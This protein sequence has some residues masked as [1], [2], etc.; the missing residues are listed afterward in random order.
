M[1]TNGIKQTEG[2]TSYSEIDWSFIEK[3][4]KC[5]NLNKGK[6]P[7]KNWQKPMEAELLLDAAQ[8]HLIELRRGELFDKENGAEHAT[9]VALNMMMYSYQTI[10]PIKLKQ[11]DAVCSGHGHEITRKYYEPTYSNLGEVKPLVI[12][13]AKPFELFKQLE[14][15]QLRARLENRKYL[16]EKQRC[17][18]LEAEIDKLKE[19]LEDEKLNTETQE[20]NCR[21]SIGRSEE[22]QVKNKELQAQIDDLNIKLEKETKY[23]KSSEA[24][25]KDYIARIEDKEKQIRKIELNNKTLKTQLDTHPKMFL[26]YC[27]QIRD[28]QLKNKELQEEIN[29]LKSNDLSFNPPPFNPY[30]VRVIY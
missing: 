17:E 23:S 5:M 4:A 30:N 24:I 15:Q 3:M 14:E 8:R 2:K 19:E 26:D 7:P 20:N 21:V 27:A 25:V 16:A 13:L 22:V 28:L 29:K 6:Y 18:D 11:H 9:A 12:D 10:T 1:Q